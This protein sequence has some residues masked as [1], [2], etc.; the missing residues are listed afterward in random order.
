MSTTRRGFISGALAALGLSR[1]KSHD[2]V[3]AGQARTVDYKT[4]PQ[5][6]LLG[7]DDPS[8]GSTV[9]DGDLDDYRYVRSQITVSGTEPST[10]LAEMTFRTG[11]GAALN[12]PGHESVD[13]PV[14]A[15]RKP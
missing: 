7:S 5:L 2:A 9:I 12:Y 8:Q 10:I 1:A 4:L 3:T 13:L 15:W 11:D 6:Q 14:V